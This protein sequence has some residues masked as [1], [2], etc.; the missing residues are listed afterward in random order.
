MKDAGPHPTAM[1][2]TS[3]R[4]HFGPPYSPA[5]LAAEHAFLESL[6]DDPQDTRIAEHLADRLPREETQEVLKQLE[7]DA[8]YRAWAAPLL[9]LRQARPRAVLAVSAHE[10]RRIEQR[11]AAHVERMRS[12]TTPL[13]RRPWL[14]LGLRVLGSVTVV[15]LFAMCGV[16]AVQYL[17]KDPRNSLIRPTHTRSSNILLDASAG[18]SFRLEPTP[19]ADG[20]KRYTVFP[21]ATVSVE[22]P[23]PEDRPTKLPV[24]RLYTRDHVVDL[25]EGELVLSL[26]QFGRENLL[27]RAPGRATFRDKA[28]PPDR[29]RPLTPISP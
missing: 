1:R 20:V 22:L 29:T 7:T 25:V 16:S 26:D 21:P 18:G 4:T 13:R 9:A 14:N 5:E 3:T 2:I 23:P 19:D 10:V 8:S 11:V 12:R 17:N 24:F 27:L 28:E 6:P 15:A